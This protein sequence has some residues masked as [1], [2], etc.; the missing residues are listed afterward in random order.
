MIEIK[1]KVDLSFG[2]PGKLKYNKE[3]F[4]K[5][6]DKF[7]NISEFIYYYRNPEK[8]ES[9]RYCKVCGKKNKF[10]INEYQKYCS[11]TCMCKDEDRKKQIAQSNKKT[12]A[13][14]QRHKEIIEQRK[15]TKLT[16][17][18]DENFNNP[19]KRAKTNLK[20]YGT[21]NLFKDVARMTQA[22]KE[23][24]G[25]EHALQRADLLK[26][27]QDTLEKHYGVRA[28]FKS[29]EILAKKDKTNLE[30][31]GTIHPTQNQVV[32]DKMTETNLKKWGFVS[33]SLN[34]EI[35]KKQQDTLEKNYGVRVSPFASKEI[36]EKARQTNKQKYGEEIYRKSQDFKDKQKQA[37]NTVG[38]D[39]LTGI[40]R[41]TQK[42]KENCLLKHGV[43]NYTQVHIKNKDLLSEEYVKANFIKDNVFLLHEFCEFY[44][45]QFS[46][47]D[48]KYRKMFNIDVPNKQYRLQTQTDIYNYVKSIYNGKVEINNRKIIQPLELDIYVPEKK[49]AI[50][51]DGLLYHSYGKSEYAIYNN[52][53][54][55]KKEH[56][57]KT[58]LCEKQGIQLFHIFE[59]EWIDINKRNIWKSVIKNKLG[60]ITNKIYARKCEIKKIDD[61]AKKNFLNDNHLQGNCSSSINLGLFYNNELVSIMTFGKSRFSDEY[62]YELLRFCNK[63]NTIV[64]GSASKLLK[65]FIKQYGKNIISY[66]NRRWSIGSL[67]EKIGFIFFI[68]REPN[69]FY[70][71]TNENILYSRIKFQKHKLKKLLAIYNEDL[72][73]TENMYNNGYRKI[74]DCGNKV[75]ILK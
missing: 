19:N 38:E 18:G 67:Y 31:W 61:L 48:V 11:R 44:N 46:V 42:Y 7:D 50:E 36:Q 60:L 15:A 12:F 1:E 65:H 66:A 10:V 24:L 52:L 13:D 28:T 30:K 53:E 32:K 16:K 49:I 55:N 58:E 35:K 23:K 27:S 72:T 54:E 8:A 41:R 59:N 71:K 43:E 75:Y 73:E 45:V 9:E 21:D 51:F 20:K 2:K 47:V 57:T 64:V 4:Q 5:Y 37:L 68:N 40:E 62:K 63:I 26:K 70:F 29:Q 17:Y 56:L 34:P 3:I 14:S 6:K 22:R 69:Y 74:F 39:G 33:A 25:V